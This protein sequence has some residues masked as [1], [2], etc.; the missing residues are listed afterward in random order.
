[1]NAFY[2]KD[3]MWTKPF[4]ILVSCEEQEI[5]S[6]RGK[7][8]ARP[9]INQI[10]LQINEIEIFSLIISSNTFQNFFTILF[11]SSE[12]KLLLIRPRT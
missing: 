2:Y 7:S 4:L 3:D 12:F 11:F 1:M 6:S 9:S 10:R 8:I 5:K